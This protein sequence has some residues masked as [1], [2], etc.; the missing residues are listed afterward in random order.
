MA[1]MSSHIGSTLKI[2]LHSQVIREAI[3]DDLMYG[4]SSLGGAHPFEN[5]VYFEFVALLNALYSPTADPEL[6]L[7]DLEVSARSPHFDPLEFLRHIF[8]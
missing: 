5:K 6:C 8:F 3:R 1:R 2:L 4:S 7:D